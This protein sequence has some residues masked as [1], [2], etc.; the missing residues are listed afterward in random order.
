MK[1]TR[2][3]QSEASWLELEEQVHSLVSFNGT[4]RTITDSKYDMQTLHLPNP[5]HRLTC[6]TVQTNKTIFWSRHNAAMFTLFRMSA[7]EW[8]TVASYLCTSSWKHLQI[9]QLTNN[10]E[11]ADTSYP[12]WRICEPAPVSWYSGCVQEIHCKLNIKNITTA[13]KRT[14]HHYYWYSIILKHTQLNELMHIW[15]HW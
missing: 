11:R 4:A 5:H 9:S 8:R 2:Q 7:Y 3:C 15:V 10:N 12:M 14:F 6:W 13:F 1:M